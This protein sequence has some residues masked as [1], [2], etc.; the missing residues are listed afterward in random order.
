MSRELDVAPLA[1][2]ATLLHVGP[3]KTGSTTLQ[4]AFN[5][6]QETLGAAGV[7]T[8]AEGPRARKAVGDLRRG[9]Q[10]WVDE[11]RGRREDG[12]S[13]RGWISNEDFASLSDDEAARLLAGL[14]SEQTQVV[15]VVRPLERLLPSQWQQRVR[16][17]LNAPTYDEWLR[18]VLGDEDGNEHHEHFWLR[19]R[20]EDQVRKWTE[21]PGRDAALL[22][23]VV[24]REGDHS[25]L[26]HVF[27][28]LMA[29]PD[30]MLVAAPSRN[31]SLTLSS[32]EFVR[33]LDHEAIALGL[34][35]VRYRD[36]L[37]VQVARALR[38]MPKD[39]AE[40]Q[41]LLPRWA[42]DRVRQLDVERVEFLKNCGATVTG[43]P[44]WLVEAAPRVREQEPDGPE[45]L[46]VERAAVLMAWALGREQKARDE[47]KEA[48]RRKRPAP[49]LDRSPLEGISSKQLVRELG[50]RVLRRR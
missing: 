2:G 50:A 6:G 8:L 47:L 18:L 26:L 25:H 27:E 16:R 43:D 39:P 3:P 5:A 36:K 22:N 11:L 42:A 1:D 49:D 30:G 13:G 10:G 32:A 34:P 44:Q 35:R 21:E 45:R 48:T 41:I 40:T 4:A 15:Y 24:A 14:G 23:F 28:R 12:A 19:H 38:D 37:K 46:S 17:S 29:L 9:G 33:N 7:R 31:S 20:L